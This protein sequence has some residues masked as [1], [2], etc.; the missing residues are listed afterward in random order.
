MAPMTYEEQ[1]QVL[2]EQ[3]AQRDSDLKAIREH[4]EYS[5]GR[6]AQAE[7][8]LQKVIDHVPLPLAERIA[9]FLESP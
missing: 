5:I 2:R 9:N 6:I 1:N 8:L 3:L 4:V 7:D